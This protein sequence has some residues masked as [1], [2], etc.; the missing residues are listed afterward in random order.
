M[1]GGSGLQVLVNFLGLTVL[2][3]QAPKDTDSSNPNNL[4]GSSC[5]FGTLSLSGAS[6]ASLAFCFVKSTNTGAGV[7]FLRLLNHKTVLDQFANVLS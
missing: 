5:I 2:L 3:Q 6:V 1:N 7:D 4:L